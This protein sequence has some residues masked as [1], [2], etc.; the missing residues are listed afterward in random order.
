MLQVN[1]K[2]FSKLTPHGQVGRPTSRLSWSAMEWQRPPRI[3][4][5]HPEEE[6]ELHGWGG[7]SSSS[8]SRSGSGSGEGSSYSE[9]EEGSNSDLEDD[10]HDSIL[11]RSFLGQGELKGQV[12]ARMRVVKDVGR[13]IGATKKQITWNL[14]VGGWTTN[15]Y[16][17]AASGRSSGPWC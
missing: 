2:R 3:G 4:G 7:S 12:F 6:T 14:I 15:W 5:S 13:R 8:S 17:T 1:G 10:L 9:E 11:D 16:C